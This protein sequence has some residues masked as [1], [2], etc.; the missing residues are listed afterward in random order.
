MIVE[1][2]AVFFYRFFLVCIFFKTYY[3]SAEVKNPKAHFAT[4][5]YQNLALFFPIFGC[6]VFLCSYK[7]GA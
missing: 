7:V 2:V 5:N 4:T 1:E 3:L 6:G